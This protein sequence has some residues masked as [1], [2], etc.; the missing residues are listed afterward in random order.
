MEVRSFLEP[1]YRLVR[2]T[3][4][5]HKRTV[6][7]LL[8]LS[9]LS[10]I[11]QGVVLLVVVR[12]VQ[13][14]DPS[15]HAAGMLKQWSVAP[16]IT[17]FVFGTLILGLGATGAYGTW[18]STL[19][20]RRV[21]RKVQEG[22]AISMLNG[23]ASASPLELSLSREQSINPYKPLT[24]GAL[25][26]SVA[27]E[28]VITSVHPIILIL[29][30]VISVMWMDWQVA[31]VAA[32]VVMLPLPMVYVLNRQ[33]HRVSARFYGKERGPTAHAFVQPMLGGQ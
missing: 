12:A 30:V 15:T 23:L 9:I 3:L 13:F 19:L 8:M 25:I 31:L 16:E 28:S 10:G 32:L 24:Q 26:L 11:C 22:L 14:V 21:A 29:S 7:L 4:G 1:Y 27:V 2:E 6:A 18:K 33:T 17:L 5:D 20:A